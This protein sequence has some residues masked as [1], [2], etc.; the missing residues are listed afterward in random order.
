MTDELPNHQIRGRTSRFIKY[1]PSINVY[2]KVREGSLPRDDLEGIMGEF[3]KD[4]KVQ[5]CADQLVVSGYFE[6]GWY[7]MKLSAPHPGYISGVAKHS[8]HGPDGRP[9]VFSVSTIFFAQ[10]EI[11]GQ[12]KGHHTQFNFRTGHS[13][14]FPKTNNSPKTH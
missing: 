5:I 14:P 1:E 8:F 6:D 4:F 9:G 7:V 2:E 3:F 13:T 12:Y 11:E 10:V